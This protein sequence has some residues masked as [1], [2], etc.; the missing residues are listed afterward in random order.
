[1]GSEDCGQLPL[2]IASNVLV[3]CSS[4]SCSHGT[5]ASLAVAK[6]Y[7]G[8]HLEAQDQAPPRHLANELRETKRLSSS[9]EGL[10]NDIADAANDLRHDLMEYWHGYDKLQAT[11]QESLLVCA[12]SEA[13]CLPVVSQPERAF[14]GLVS[15]SAQHPAANTMPSLCTVNR[16][17]LI[18][19]GG[20]DWKTTLVKVKLTYLV[21]S[22]DVDSARSFQLKIQDDSLFGQDT[23]IILSASC[24]RSRDCWLSVLADGHVTISRWKASRCGSYK[25]PARNKAGFAPLVTWI[26]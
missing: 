2:V 11:H 25:P 14:R 7:S 23:R 5:V 15:I 22:V 12:A 8:E 9:W 19:M 16:S 17:H 26:S 24:Q 21:V 6:E 20:A 1:M 13:A 18:L 10:V 3:A 4:T